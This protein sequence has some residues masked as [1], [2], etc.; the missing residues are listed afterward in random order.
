LSA[1]E[2]TVTVVDENG[3]SSISSIN[4]IAPDQLSFTAVENDP[5]F[6]GLSTGSIQLTS[7]E[8]GVL[9]LG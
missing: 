7:I 1:G 4:L 9:N 6:E 3:C 5:N 2:H 8:G